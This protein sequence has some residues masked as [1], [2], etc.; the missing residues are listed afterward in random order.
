VT[1][2]SPDRAAPARPAA[3]RAWIAA[4][5]P[6]TLGASV[7]PVVLG[8]AVA[9][10]E[11]RAHAGAAL[12]ALAVAVL[13][14]IGTNLHNDLADHARGADGPGRL[15]PPRAA[16]SGWIGSRRLLAAAA[17]CF[18]AAAVVGL[19]LVGRA[20]PAALAVGAV[21]VLAGLAYTGGPRPLGYLGLGEALVFVFFGP[22]AV[23]GTYWVQALDVSRFA[24]ACSVPAGWLA[25]AI[26]VVNNV[27]DR[28]GDRAAGKRTL[29]A[30]FGR[31]PC[32]WLF[33]ALVLGAYAW[34]AVLSLAGIASPRAL[35]AVLV[36]APLAAHALGAMVSR[37]GAA[38]NGVLGAAA[39]LALVFDCALALGVST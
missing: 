1:S 23:C 10:A 35:V 2:A 24:A 25:A 26:L 8:T 37:D 39:R 33:G 20:G 21:S 13:L 11:G 6:A 7:G 28:E 31:G 18:A 27:R 9:A 29:A 30:R 19:A 38:L 32:L 3:A 17:A 36:T 22:V 15:G 12:G 34:V 5:R 4:L 16:A 14:Q